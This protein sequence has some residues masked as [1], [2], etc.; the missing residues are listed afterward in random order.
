M[1]ILLRDVNYG[2]RISRLC[3]LIPLLVHTLFIYMVYL[4]YYNISIVSYKILLIC[5]ILINIEWPIVAVYEYIYLSNYVIFN[6][7]LFNIALLIFLEVLLFMGFYWLYINNIIHSSYISHI[8]DV[9]SYSVLDSINTFNNDLCLISILYNLLI[10]LYVTLILQYVHRSIN[11]ACNSN[12]NNLINS[13]IYILIYGGI[14]IYSLIIIVQLFYYRYIGI[15]SYI[16]MEIRNRNNINLYW[17]L[18]NICI[19]I[20]ITLISH[21]IFKIGIY[22]S[23]LYNICYWLIGTGLGL[24][25]IPFIVY[26]IMIISY[27]MDA[28]SY[29]LN[30]SNNIILKYNSICTIYNGTNYNS[31]Y[32]L[33]DISIVLSII[34]SIYYLLNWLYQVLYYGVRMWLV[35]VLHEFSLG[36]FGELLTV[37]SDNNMIMNIFY[38]GL[39]GM[40]IIIYLI[41]VFYLGI[42]I[43][44]YISFSLY[45]L[46]TC[47]LALFNDIQINK[48][49][50][51]NDMIKYYYLV[52]VSLVDVVNINIILY[53]VLLLSVFLISIKLILGLSN[54][55]IDYHYYNNMNNNNSNILLSVNNSNILS[56]NISYYIN[57]SHPYKIYVLLNLSLSSGLY[58]STYMISKVS[59]FMHLVYIY[60]SNIL[61]IIILLF[62]LL[63]PII[64]IVL[65]DPFIISSINN[66]IYNN[67]ISRGVYLYNNCT[68]ISIF[69]LG[70]NIY[71]V[72]VLFI[73]VIINIIL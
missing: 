43:Y 56:T 3:Y 54:S 68:L 44:V 51:V 31:I 53:V 24:Y 45:F 60:N 27:V 15:S 50:N 30:I 36:S 20:I 14:C 33:C 23:I 7:L 26:G 19:I 16:E 18:S 12:N 5:I 46:S 55:S 58:I 62:Y 37:V 70:I 32:L 22:S 69:L 8:N 48:L 64:F 21:I 10:L 61:I 11:I 39:L 41:V 40:G 57:S 1:L 59:I 34:R 52:P 47:I 67:S 63:Y 35:F 2:G 13:S 29:G 28:H 9:I 66:N 17:S 73:D 4:I 25:I 6:N 71:I 72:Y 38:F 65:I 42:Q 49:I